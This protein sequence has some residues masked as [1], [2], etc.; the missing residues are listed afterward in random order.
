VVEGLD[1]T[2]ATGAILVNEIG[3]VSVTRLYNFQGMTGQSISRS[4]PMA[5]ARGLLRRPQ[6]T[7][8]QHLLNAARHCSPSVRLKRR[9]SFDHD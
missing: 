4:Q 3:T 8:H 1:A 6:R 2:N 5:I 9:V 7:E